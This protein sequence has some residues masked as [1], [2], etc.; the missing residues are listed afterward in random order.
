MRKRTIKVTNFN[1]KPGRD[2]EILIDTEALEA[3]KNMDKSN[4]YQVNPELTKRKAKEL[5]LLHGWDKQQLLTLGMPEKHL[6]TWLY[7]PTENTLSWNQEKEIFH[8]SILEKMKEHKATEVTHSLG[9]ALG[10][11]KR[12]LASIDL[13]GTILNI[14][15]LHKLTAVIKDLDNIVRLEEGKPTSIQQDL[16]LS[17]AQVKKI[18][19]E[20][21]K[22]DPFISYNDKLN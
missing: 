15:Q 16:N 18:V 17:Q 6:N 7:E 20:L 12:S 3:A 14:N 2:R 4:P 19:E 1:P 21:D 22:L 8:T 13:D 10:I 5:F 9:R 11:A